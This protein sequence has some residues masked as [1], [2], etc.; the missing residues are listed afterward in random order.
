[1]AKDAKK[2]AAGF[3]EAERMCPKCGVRMAS[4]ADRYA[5]GRC[6]FTEWKKGKE[7]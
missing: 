1:M 2:K 6:G 7:A 5:C 4:H 3:K